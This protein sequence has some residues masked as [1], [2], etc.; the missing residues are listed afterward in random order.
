MITEKGFRI[1]NL[2]GVLVCDRPMIAQF[3]PKIR[4][5]W[6]EAFGIDTEQVNLK[7]KTNEGLTGRGPGIEATVVAL[8]VQGG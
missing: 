5:S 2:D 8:L 7:G 6:A 1:V 4:S 3:R